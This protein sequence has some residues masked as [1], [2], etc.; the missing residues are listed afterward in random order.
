MTSSADRLAIL[1]LA[2]AALVAVA[3]GAARRAGASAPTAANAAPAGAAAPAPPIGL[4]RRVSA[5]LAERLAAPDSAIRL[6]W[7]RWPALAPPDPEAPFRLV[8]R[9]DGGWFVVVFESAGRAIP[10]RLRAGVEE[11]VAVAARPLAAGRRLAASD[12]A[13]APRVR[14]GVGARRGESAPGPGWDVRRSLAAGDV[15]APPAV[16]PPAVIEP[17]SAVE[18]RWRSGGVSVSVPGIALE[19]ARLGEKVA[20][21]VAGRPGRR[22]GVAVAP[23]VVALDAGG[24]R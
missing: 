18:L 12:L 6:Q 8:G 3:P 20:V 15:L 4:D 16:V 22:V 7:G 10:V 11:I 17:S 9:G 2:A 23:G 5:A 24:V 19:A 1:A 13:A 21:K 14:W